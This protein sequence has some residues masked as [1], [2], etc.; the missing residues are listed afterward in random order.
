MKTLPLA[1]FAVTLLTAA[2]PLTT[3]VQAGTGIQRC[4]VA[5]GTVVYTDKACAAFG[6]APRPLPSDVLNRIAREEARTSP[7]SSY[8]DAAASNAIA[9][10]RRSPAAGCARTP[11]Q[12][13]MDLRGSLALRD[14][15]RLAESYH[16]VGMTHAQSKPIMQKLERLAPQ[17]LE[18]VHFLDAQ[19][20]TGGMQLADATASNAAVTGVMQ[21]RFGGELRQ[22]LDFNV[23]RYA[24]CYFIRF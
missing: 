15:N 13:S 11:T 5:D 10:A 21:L 23:E 7:S 20:G 8:P 17:P 24:G 6:A 19:I 16:W 14:V 3:P 2:L 1:A 4:Q 12:L 9:V 18:E 22:V